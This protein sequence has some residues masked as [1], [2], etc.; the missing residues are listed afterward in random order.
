MLGTNSG[1]TANA[2]F[3]IHDS[4]GPATPVGRKRK[5]GKQVAFT[6]RESTLA[7]QSPTRSSTVK[8]GYPSTRSILK[9]T[10]P[11]APQS[12]ASPAEL[13]DQNAAS[14]LTELHIRPER[15]PIDAFSASSG[16]AETTK[17]NSTAA[18]DDSTEHSMSPGRRPV[19]SDTTNN[20]GPRL[21]VH[22]L[23]MHASVGSPLDTSRFT[24]YGRSGRP[25][26]KWINF[27]GPPTSTG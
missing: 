14:G 3:Y 19:L 13:S 7:P 12:G 17:R 1:D 4:S 18:A 27:E 9:P 20:P 5:K 21:P 25:V 8:S 22:G 11:D 2:D 6:P 15:N 24:R 23:P 16:S 10:N 26:K